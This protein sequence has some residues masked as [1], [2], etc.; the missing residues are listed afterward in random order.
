MRNLYYALVGLFLISFQSAFAQTKMEGK[1][2]D[3]D[4]KEAL[5]GVM[6]GIEGTKVSA[7]TDIDGRFSLSIPENLTSRKLTVSFVG[8]EKQLFPVSASSS[9]VIKLKSSNVLQEVVVQSSLAGK[10]P[11]SQIATA[12]D[13]VAVDDLADK[14]SFN[15]VADLMNGRS[16]S[17][18][19]YNVNGKVGTGIRFNTRASATFSLQR[20][21]IVFIDG[22]RV[23]TSN[24]SDV[25]SAQES[26]GGLNDL[27]PNDIESIEV[28]KGPAASASYGS[29]AANGVV[30][31]TT[32]KGSN[33][34]ISVN[35]KYS[36][37]VNV[38]ANDYDYLVNN[39]PI[40]DFYTTGN[41]RDIYGS[42]NGRSGEYGRFNVS[43]NHRDA[44]SHVPGNSDVRQSFK[45]RYDYTREKYS[46]GFSNQYSVGEVVMP[47][48]GSG[49]YDATWNLVRNQTPWPYLMEESWEAR[50]VKYNNNRFLGNFYAT[51]SPI[52]NLEFKSVFGYDKNNVDGLSLMPYGYA[53]GSTTKGQKTLS[54]REDTNL[55]W[56]VSATY[57]LTVAE[58]HDLSATL[59]SQ[60]N[61][62][63]S[64]FGSTTVKDFAGPGSDGMGSG[65]TITNTNEDTFEKR[66]HGIYGEVTYGFQNKLYV[67]TGLRRDASNLIGSNV[68]SIWYPQ[69]NVAYNLSEEDFMPEAFDMFKLRV[70]YGESGRLPHP[71]DATTTY[72][73]VQTPDGPSYITYIK[74]NPDIKPE[75]TREWEFGTD[76]T[77]GPLDFNVT[78]F[79]QRTVDAIIYTDLKP[80]EGWPTT[81]AKY[82]Q[83]AGEIEGNGFE[84]AVNYR[85]Y[86]SADGRFGVNI[87]GNVNRQESEV[88]DTQGQE[89]TY[90][91]STIQEGLPAYAFYSQKSQGAKFNEDGTYKGEVV[92]EY[93]YMGNPFPEYQG[94]FG[95]DLKLFRNF[96]AS[97]LFTFATNFQI[98]NISARNIA[99]SGDNYEAKESAKENMNS[100]PVGSPEYIRWANELSKYE[101]S[102]GN[103][104]EDGDFLRLSNVTL[105][106]DLTDLAHRIV[107]KSKISHVTL[108]ATGSNLWLSSG[109]SGTD[110]LVAGEGGS[111]AKRGMSHIGSDWTSV[112]APK[113]FMFTLSVGI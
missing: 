101:S 10:K 68:S 37:G 99:R 44:E 8:Y 69:A 9:L 85:A 54:N 100:H 109:Y 43:F 64:E 105:S 26:L 55:N 32:K 22:I 74:G 23:N 47:P 104:I 35:V 93:E 67:T 38:L 110:P 45:G 17:M 103:F 4:T 6:L 19:L 84:L 95:L 53:Y 71:E 88:V 113:T 41:V 66:T 2:V 52:E 20:D 90:F 80:S 40:N 86:E 28:L 63:K 15:S 65:G 58:G 49:K 78:Y 42:V 75:R 106:Y 82:A 62:S 7:Q 60:L 94:S 97:A 107:D 76:I 73:A 36:E 11:A 81:N 83:N 13:R 31:I 87:F 89:F 61:S 1:V 33:E 102:R 79:D 12:Y 91:A 59:V 51:Y 14:Q 92:G 18:Q 108:S 5:V 34:D 39:D 46:F 29:E 77:I 56:E 48:T 3:L 57:S 112:P 111:S 24:I 72:K 96:S 98:Y 30:F 25:S 16:G 27:N 50:E 21:P 70:A